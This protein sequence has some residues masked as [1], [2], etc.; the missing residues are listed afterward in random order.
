[1]K[2]WYLLY[3][4]RGQVERAASNLALQS[5]NYFYPTRRAEKMVR[6]IRKFVNEPLFPNYLFIQFNPEEIH[7]TTIS[8]TRGVSYF[9]RKGIEPAIVPEEIIENLK[10][11][12]DTSI[13][14]SALPQPG[15]T[16]TI[17]SGIFKGLEAIYHEQDGEK[18]SILLVKMLGNDVKKT[19][20]NT[21]FDKKIED[22]SV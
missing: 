13:V 14:N 19:I 18:R 6:G 8:G 21:D 4:K 3:C 12:R 7:T 1:M 22:E 11:P 20:E 10:I 17:S 15:D 2:S 5:V 9:I 16:V